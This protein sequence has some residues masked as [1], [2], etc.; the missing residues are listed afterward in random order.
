M[1]KKE[2]VSMIEIHYYIPRQF[3]SIFDE[4][5]DKTVP[6]EY[7]PYIR[8][9]FK[10]NSY[11]SRNMRSAPVSILQLHGKILYKPRRGSIYP[12]FTE[13]I[14]YIYRSLT[15]LDD[16]SIA[17]KIYDCMVT[18]ARRI[19]ELASREEG[20]NETYHFVCDRYEA[21][22][23]CRNPEIAPLLLGNAPVGP[24]VHSN[25]HNVKNNVL[26]RYKTATGI[27]TVKLI[28]DPDNGKLLLST[29]VSG[30]KTHPA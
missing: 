24:R 12:L 28:G 9:M 1:T 15:V 19:L 29:E 10:K 3:S 21:I 11:Q 23:N 4:E 22:I 7:H 26:W 17:V 25:Q 30:H 18:T 5:L 8:A 13:V 2:R 20:P 6:K 27:R 14:Y 16:I